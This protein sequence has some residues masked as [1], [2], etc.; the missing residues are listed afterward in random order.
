MSS[1]SHTRINYDAIAPLYDQQPYRDKT[2]D[3]HLIAFAKDAPRCAEPLALLDLGCGTGNQLVANQRTLDVGLWVGLDLSQGM[4]RQAQAK[5]GAVSWIQAD[6]AQP[7]FADQSFDFITSQFAFH[8]VQNQST[9]IHTV[10]ALLKPGGR[11]VMTNIAPHE[12]PLALRLLGSTAVTGRAV[13]VSSP[14]R[15]PPEG[16]Y[17]KRRGKR[18]F[19]KPIHIHYT[20]LVLHTATNVPYDRVACTNLTA[21]KQ[22]TYLPWPVLARCA[23]H[24][25]GIRRLH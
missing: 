5:T 13:A 25:C 9:M 23:A 12:M 17:R 1:R 14:S 21:L 18:A 6:S 20:A 8:H 11:F 22:E 10:Y 3:P 24:W 16:L 19:E 2:V 7:P 15:R 4:L